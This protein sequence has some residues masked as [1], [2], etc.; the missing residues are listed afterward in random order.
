MPGMADDP[1]RVTA[2]VPLPAEAVRVFT[3]DLPCE[4]RVPEERTPAA[5]RAAVAGA[6]VVIGDFT[7][8]LRV[9]AELVASAARLAFVQQPTVG[10]ESVDLAACTAAGV[11]VA[12]T[13]G[14][15]AV[16]VAEWCV[17]GALAALR[18]AGWA[19]RE[20]R[21]GGWPQLEIAERGCVELSGRR[22]GIAGFGPIGREA[23]R[24]FAAFDCPVAYWSR[25]RRDPAEAAGAEYMTLDE[26][27]TTSDV[28][29]VVVALTGETRG[30]LDRDRLS[31]LPRGAVVVNAARGGIV[32]EEA[33]ADLLDSGHVAAAALDVFETEPLPAASR[34]RGNDRVLLSPHVA[35]ATVQGRLRMVAAVTA[36][37]RRALSGEPVLD[38]CNQVDPLVH[39]R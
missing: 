3:G 25:R 27:V 24:R 4:V 5:A 7:G 18:S 14:A 8:Q 38:V 6:D 1:W 10:V 39:R 9:D 32:D 20:V 13:A 37:L 16:S 19:D 36:N 23:A 21:A 35:G 30:L 11:P 26:L 33:L 15:N 12:N 2:L 34:L 31:R 29:V 22:V 28:L 17:F